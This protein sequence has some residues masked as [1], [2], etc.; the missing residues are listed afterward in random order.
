MIYRT[1]VVTPAY[2][3]QAD[4]ADIEREM[5]GLVWAARPEFDGTPIR[6]LGVRRDGKYRS[7]AQEHSNP[8]WLP[9][10]RSRIVRAHN[11]VEVQFERI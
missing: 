3:A 5:V 4:M 9:L 7:P 10:R 1:T 2:F 8:E 6:I 11:A